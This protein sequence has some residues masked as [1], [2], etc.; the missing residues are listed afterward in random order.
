MWY[1]LLPVA[2]LL[3]RRFRKPAANEVADPARNVFISNLTVVV[4]S[5][6]YII[7]LELLVGFPVSNLMFTMVLAS[8]LMGS[9]SSI[10]AN[11][12]APQLPDAGGWRK[13]YKMKFQAAAQWLAVVADKSPDFSYVFLC[14]VFL[15]AAPNLLVVMIIFR[16]SVL[17]CN[18][19]AAKN[20]PENRIYVRIKPMYD[21]HVKP[22]EAQWKHVCNVLEIV[23]GFQLIVGILLPSRQILT[24]VVYWHFLKLR[25]SMQRSHADALAAW[26]AV[27][28]RAGPVPRFIPAFIMNR[29]KGWFSRG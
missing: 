21:K 18:A 27:E 23:L 11:Y 17:S 3:Y 5:I 22:R 4:A 13:G 1:W 2:V 20:M 16:R 8:T 28:E 29:I 26:K 24:T 12:G 19:F 7:P 25:F 10:M 6:V 14:A 9:G 15:P